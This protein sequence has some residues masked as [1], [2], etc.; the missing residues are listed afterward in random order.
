MAYQLAKALKL[1]NEIEN[2]LRYY[3]RRHLELL[4]LVGDELGSEQHLLKD[5]TQ[6]RKSKENYFKRWYKEDLHYTKVKNTF[7]KQ[8]KD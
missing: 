7:D 2:L 8:Q 3:F 1:A 4:D 6:I 5:F